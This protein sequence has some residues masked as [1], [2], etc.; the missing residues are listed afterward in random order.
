MGVQTPMRRD[1]IWVVYI[2]D[3]YLRGV[4]HTCGTGLD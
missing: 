4:G 2:G 1:T 3:V